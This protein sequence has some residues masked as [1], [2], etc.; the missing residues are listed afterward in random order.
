MQLNHWLH[1]P[2]CK[3]AVFAPVEI[4]C[5]L[6]WW[7]PLAV[8]MVFLALAMS[9][10]EGAYPEPER[11]NSSFPLCRAVSTGLETEAMACVPFDGH[12]TIAN[13]FFRKE[14]PLGRDGTARADPTTFAGWQVVIRADGFS[15][16]YQ[17]AYFTDATAPGW[18]LWGLVDFN[19]RTIYLAD[20]ELGR[21]VLVHEE[22]HVLFPPPFTHADWPQLGCDRVERGVAE[23]LAL[24]SGVY[25]GSASEGVYD[26]AEARRYVTGDL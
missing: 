8:L 9:C 19:T 22:C 24:A 1:C 6:L 11:T 21:A 13:H 2:N 18:L 10:G 16:K 5:A 14:T 25:D 20:A 12:E 7:V 23:A 4:A 17:R 3:H 15:E 26:P